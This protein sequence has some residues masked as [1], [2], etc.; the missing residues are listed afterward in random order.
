TAFGFSTIRSCN[1]CATSSE[2]CSLSGRIFTFTIVVPI[3]LSQ[4]LSVMA[5]SRIPG[6]APV[7]RAEEG[8]NSTKKFR[9]LENRGGGR[10]RT[11]VQGR[12]DRNLVSRALHHVLLCAQV[13]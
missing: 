8:A 11:C 4:K 3:L 7:L 13:V 1:I 12:A 9:T 5:V 6:Q 2:A 10:I